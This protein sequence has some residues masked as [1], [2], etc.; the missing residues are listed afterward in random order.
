MNL[1][2]IVSLL[3]SP[4]VLAASLAAQEPDKPKP[5]TAVP[6]PAEP[7]AKPDKPVTLAIGAAIEKTVSLA[8]ID[9]KQFDFGSVR[10]KP[11]VLHFWSIVC[12]YE[13]AAEPKLIALA[14]AWG[15]KVTVLAVNANSSEIG[16]QPKP[17]AFEADDEKDK[18]YASIRAH[19]KSVE[20]NH[21]ILVDHS[22][23]FARLLDGK[24]TPH[25]FVF[26]AE[27][28]LRYQGALDDDSAGDKGDEA[29][30]YVKSAVDAL[31]AGKPVE[32]ETTRPYG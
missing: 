23:D 2:P 4:C 14:K 16:A 24:T 31:L 32:V 30:Q 13:K 22:G 9:G 7:E 12:P 20:F 6:K 1:H 8:D 25:C 15:D 11:V 27:G 18:P 5:D 10:G 21:K 26:D 28:V 3:L 19:A 17:E 29:K